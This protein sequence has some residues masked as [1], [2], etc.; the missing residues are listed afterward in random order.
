MAG[1][2]YSQRLILQYGQGPFVYT[3]PSGQ[4]AI[5]KQLTAANTSA[6]AVK[7]NVYMLGVNVWFADVPGGS[8][9][10]ASGLH[11]VV[12]ELE[13][14]TMACIAGSMSLS[15]HGYVLSMAG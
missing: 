4:R 11:I 8:C 5:V 12:N 1:R 3:P 10:V 9:A 2:V 7:L 14:F 13:A 15:A 6:A